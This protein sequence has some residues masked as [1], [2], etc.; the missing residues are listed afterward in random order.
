MRT[1]TQLIGRGR[2]LIHPTQ[3]L[4]PHSL[5]QLLQHRFGAQIQVAL[6]PKYSCASVHHRFRLS[7]SR[8]RV[9]IT[10]L[11]GS[12][13]R[14]REKDLLAL[15]DSVSELMLIERKAA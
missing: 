5:M 6:G 8:H 11:H 10:L 4:D 2:V 9:V 14:T 13:L 12:S 3:P 15:Q 1:K 7:A